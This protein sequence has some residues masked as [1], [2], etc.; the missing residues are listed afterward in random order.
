MRVAIVGAGISSLVAAHLLSRRHQVTVFEAADRI[1][2]HTNT[3]DIELGG[4]SWP[5]DTGFIVFNNKTYPNFT[6]LMDQIGV[7]R[8][9]SD[10]SFSV[11]DEESGLEYNGTSLNSLFAQRSNLFRPSF[12][13][14]I[15]E[16]MRFNREAP[17][18]LE[19]DE[20][21]DTLDNYLDRHGYNGSF[22]KHYLIPMGAAIWS[23]PRSKLREFPIGFFVRFF[24]NHGFLSV[25][26]RP[27]WYVIEGGSR[28]YL[29]PLCRP[30]AESIRTGTPVT[31]IRRF[32]RHVEVNGESFDEVVI[33]AHSDQALKML[34]DPSAQ[35]TE[36]LS[37]LPYQGN[38]AVLHTDASLLPQRKLAWA[39][40][41]YHLDGSSEDLPVPVTYN[42][43]MLQGLDA[44]ETFCVTLN[45]DAAIAKEKILAEVPYHHP[46]Y[47][48]EG[49]A[50]QR[51]HGEISGERLTHYCGAYWRYGFHEDGVVSGLRVAE[52]FGEQL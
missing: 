4:R 26:D 3:L 44:P 45:R 2:G 7:S 42:M 22:R 52:R 20:A 35:E 27:Q 48:L 13:N 5:V 33:G 32:E 41:N 37:A 50:A 1:G 17:D 23:M 25:N 40:W 18:V 15:R 51:R 10:M 19:T 8:K 16:I 39:S 38:T 11:R 9:D 30:F 29:E 14:M 49:I 34:D 6:K 24:H 47:S 31:S 46:V 36:I 12:W 28:S 21:N 43:N